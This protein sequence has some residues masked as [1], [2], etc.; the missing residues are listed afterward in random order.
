MN[1]RQF[2]QR[3]KSFLLPVSEE[4]A[5]EGEEKEFFRNVVKS[6]SNEAHRR[7][8]P[9]PYDTFFGIGDKLTVS[10]HE[11]KPVGEVKEY[12]FGEGHTCI[13]YLIAL[14]ESTEVWCPEEGLYGLQSRGGIIRFPVSN[15]TIGLESDESS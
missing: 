8:L 11:S 7:K 13:E 4:L 15:K 5:L 1:N 9:N 6:F 2:Q 12:R 10:I 3:F 14:D